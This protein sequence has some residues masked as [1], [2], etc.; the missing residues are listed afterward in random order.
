MKAEDLGLKPE[1]KVV[2]A[3]PNPGGLRF[4][5]HLMAVDAQGNLYLADV[6][7]QMLHKLNRTASRKVPPD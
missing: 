1:Q 5:P 7:N 2:P 6:S 3:I 4:V